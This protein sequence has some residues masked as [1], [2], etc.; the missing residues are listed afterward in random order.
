VSR[1]PAPVSSR[2]E[3]GISGRKIDADLRDELEYTLLSA[4]IGVATTT[5]TLN[6][7]RDRVERA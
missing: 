7:I 3:D 2:L 5:V 6:R 1:K 4:D